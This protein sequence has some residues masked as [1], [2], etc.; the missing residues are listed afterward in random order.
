MSARLTGH[1]EG[2]TLKIWWATVRLDL[3]LR[4][5]FFLLF[6]LASVPVAAGIPKPLSVVLSLV[7]SGLPD[8][9]L[10]RSMLPCGHPP[11]PEIGLASA[12]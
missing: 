12:A 3:D 2:V 5:G 4:N 10:T 8:G 11:I 6:A 9:R 1:C 7:A